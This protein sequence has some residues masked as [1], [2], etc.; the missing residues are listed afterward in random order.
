[1][2]PTAA[3][4]RPQAQDLERHAAAAPHLAAGNPRAMR[5][6]TRLKTLAPPRLT[7][8]TTAQA[9][10]RASCPAI[11]GMCCAGRI[12][13]RAQA[14]AA[15]KQP[16]DAGAAV[17]TGWAGLNA[18]PSSAINP[19]HKEAVDLTMKECEFIVIFYSTTAFEASRRVY[20]ALRCR[21]IDRTPGT[22]AL[23]TPTG[24]ATCHPRT[25]ALPHPPSAVDGPAVVA[26]QIK[27]GASRQV[28]LVVGLAYSPDTGRANAKAT[29]QPVFGCAV[30]TAAF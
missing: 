27:H 10:A 11:W 4:D 3:P 19:N 14:C 20:I 16:P 29:F 18:H 5:S 26:A 17:A 6:D 22:P 1:M 2:G 13:R 9:V 15:D 21:R 25:V 12:D 28:E 24:R 8:T 7:P 30:A 23:A